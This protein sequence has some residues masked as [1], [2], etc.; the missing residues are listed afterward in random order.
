MSKLDNKATALFERNSQSGFVEAF[1]KREIPDSPNFRQEFV[2]APLSQEDDSAIQLLL[3][4]Q[5]IPESEEPLTAGDYKSL[6]VLTQQIRAIDR[7]SILLHGERIQTAQE[8]LKK[9]RE[10]T[11]TSWLKLTYGNRQTPYRML[12]FY[13]L[14]QRL[15]RR[16]QPLLEHM[17]KKVAYALAMRE[18]DLSKKVEIIREHHRD[19]PSQILQVIQAVLPLSEG[20]RRIKRTSHDEAILKILEKGIRTLKKR[21]EVLPE[22]VKARLNALKE[23]IQAILDSVVIR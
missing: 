11:F 18:G 23:E 5:F 15:E 22:I 20:D 6:Y 8:V 14:F 13:E 10:G 9:Y 3:F 17:P 19:E 4:E 12:R 7:Q 2:A 1:E 16:D 21:K